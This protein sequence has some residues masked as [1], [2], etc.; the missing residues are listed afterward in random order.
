MTFA[1]TS[2]NAIQDR[3]GDDYLRVERSQYTEE[4]NEF[5]GQIVCEWAIFPDEGAVWAARVTV[6][7]DNVDRKSTDD[8]YEEMIAIILI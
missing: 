5:E 3:T 6:V 8:D 7:D 2:Y 4:L 1:A